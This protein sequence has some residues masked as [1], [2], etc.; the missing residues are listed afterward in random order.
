MKRYFKSIAGV[1]LLEILLVLAIASMIIVM[2][3]RFY[4][5]ATTSENSNIIMEDI[6]NIT[7][8]ADNIAQGNGSYSG[9]SNSTITAIAGAG[10]M[11]SPYGGAFTI[12]GVGGS[13][14]S[15]QLSSVP[16]NV[17]SNIIV[18][19]KA[20]TKFSGPPAC[21]GTTLTYTYDANS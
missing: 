2:S 16:S 4:Q 17:C 6:Q 8:A 12:T 21:N 5:N 1:T 13:S 3:I 10:N 19:L 14:Y 15:V 18:R 9:V 7:A 11:R 20:N